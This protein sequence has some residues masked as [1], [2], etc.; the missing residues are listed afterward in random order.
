[1]ETAT[2]LTKERRVLSRSCRRPSAM[3]VIAMAGGEAEGPIVFYT[4]VERRKASRWNS[5]P[6]LDQHGS[7]CALRRSA[8]LRGARQTA[9]AEERTNEKQD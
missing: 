5:R 4:A 8:P 7:V 9:P 1:M 6:V 3:E 2:S